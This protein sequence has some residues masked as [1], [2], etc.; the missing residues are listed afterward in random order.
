MEENVLEQHQDHTHVTVAIHAS[1]DQSVK[2][3][4]QVVKIE[5]VV[6]ENVSALENAHQLVFVILVTMVPTAKSNQMFAQVTHV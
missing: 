5:T 4:N 2:I 3:L 6:M 1:A